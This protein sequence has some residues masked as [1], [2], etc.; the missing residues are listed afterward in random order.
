MLINELIDTYEQYD[1]FKQLL[2]NY[3]NFVQGDNGKFVHDV[4][5]TTKL[6]ILNEM[7]SA[8]HTKLPAAEKDITQRAYYQID[9][10]LDFLMAPM[11]IINERRE[12]HKAYQSMGAVTPNPARKDKKNDR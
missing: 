6:S 1:E 2:E 7:L 12:R 8:R 3:H 9:Q 5:K 4:L 11:R 10:M